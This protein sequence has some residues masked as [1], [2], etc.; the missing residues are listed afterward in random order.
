L[1]AMRLVVAIVSASLL[2]EHVVGISLVHSG[3]IPETVTD[4]DTVMLAEMSLDAAQVQAELEE[5][6]QSAVVGQAMAEAQL[7]KGCN[8]KC[9]VD[10]YPRLRNKQLEAEKGN[11]DYARRHWLKF[12]R[13]AGKNCKCGGPENIFTEVVVNEAKEAVK[14]RLESK[15]IAQ[16]NAEVEALI[17]GC[18][19]NCYV[20][21]YPRL[22]N[23]KWEAEK[24]NLDYARDHFINFGHDAGRNCFC[25]TPKTGD[26]FVR[27]FGAQKIQE[28]AYDFNDAVL[29]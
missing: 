29:P 22:R 3:K 4:A 23:A 19:W 17:K 6:E 16:A 1:I 24:N 28:V 2:A 21:R 9:Y 15:K 18:D 10:R 8:W 20:E 25:D 26:N 27:R 14:E 12:G 7:T 11:S 5:S 13:F